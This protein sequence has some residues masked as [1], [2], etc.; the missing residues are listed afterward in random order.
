MKYRRIEVSAF[1]RRVTIVSGE[2]PMD[3]IVDS[4]IA[5][6]H[7]DVSL[8]DK[9]SSEPV[10]PESDEGQLIIVEAIRSLE[11]HLLPDVHVAT[12]SSDEAT[13]LEPPSGLRSRFQSLYRLIHRK[14]HNL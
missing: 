4:R 10:S 11:R 7:D 5:E 9:D 2:W 8:N 6:V 12:S 1:Q 14:N 3:D 13:S